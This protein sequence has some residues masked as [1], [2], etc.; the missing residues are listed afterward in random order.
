M[1]RALNEYQIGGIKTTLPFFRE[2]V[3]DEVF[4]SG[5]LDTGF[6]PAF[7][8]RREKRPEDADIQ[9][10]A[11]IA[12]ALA[13]SETRTADIPLREAKSEWRNAARIGGLRR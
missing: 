11:L 6:I 12:A 2:V 9:T 3:R 10:V 13:R 1:K 7:E 4:I 8:T 5:S